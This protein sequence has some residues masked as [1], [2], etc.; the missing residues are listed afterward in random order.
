VAVISDARESRRNAAAGITT[1]A[2][3]CKYTGGVAMCLRSRRAITLI[4]PNLDPQQTTLSAQDFTLQSSQDPAY[5][6]PLAAT[7]LGFDRQVTGYI[8]DRTAI[9]ETRLHL[10]LPHALRD[11]LSYQLHAPAAGLAELPVSWRA[12]QLSGSIQLNQVG[13]LPAARKRAYIGNWLGSAGAM[14]V[15]SEDFRVID[16]DSG[17]PVLTGKLEL[18]AA[19][20]PWSGN[21]VYLADFS[22]LHKTGHY[23]L[24]VPGLGQSDSFHI[25]ADVYADVYRTTGR[26]FYHHR[27]GTVIRAPWAA[28]GHE[29]PGGIPT[30]FDGVFHKDVADSPLGNKEPA[31]GYHAVSGGWFDAGDYGQYMPNAAPVWYVISAALDIA[32][33]QFRDGDLDI[34]ESGNGLPDLVDEL[35]W[36][37]DWA[38]Q[39]QDPVDGGVYFR[40]ASATWDGSL[41]HAI[42]KPRLIAEKTTHATAAFAAMAAIHARLLA[43]DRPARAATVLAAARHAWQFLQTHPQWPAEGERYHNPKG[44]NAGEYPDTSAQDNILWAAAE[45]Y[46]STGETAYHDACLALVDKVKIDPTGVVSFKDQGMAA[47]WAYLM[48]P[49]PNKDKILVKRARDIFLAAADWRI[50]KMQEHPYHAPVHQYRGYLGWGSFAHSSRATLTLFQAWHLSGKPDYLQWA[51]QTTDAQLGANPQSISYIT[52]IGARSP[53]FPLS[54][55]SQYDDLETPLPGIPV[56]GPHAHL[57]ALWAST[58]AVNAAYFPAAITPESNA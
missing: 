22:A 5:K 54:K 26:Y 23:R 49:W 14:P 51:W 38:L 42:E 25:G 24:Q 20:D 40:I 39:M 31:N 46:R 52:G 34:P 50:R 16:A 21:D 1:M 4:L 9:T 17:K 15:D 43:K 56:N 7:R 12:Q 2:P 53:R 55:L 36:G 6:R 48:A 47:H 30:R 44:I 37:M 27:N 35:E 57:P 45:L 32:P 41:P 33:Q 18:R 8:D 10:L 19:S 3:A 29:R 11:D 58:R 28:P 13:Y